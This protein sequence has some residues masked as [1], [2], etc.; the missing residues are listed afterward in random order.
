MAASPLVIL[1]G[2]AVSLR[3]A[4]AESEDPFTAC[5]AAT[6]SRHFYD[7][8]RRTGGENS[9]THSAAQTSCMGPST[10]HDLSP[11][12]DHTSLRMTGI[13]YESSTP[14]AT[15]LV[16]ATWISSQ[17]GDTVCQRSIAT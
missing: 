11:A 16:M 10:T 14:P 13:G 1:S 8:Q 15:S 12:K 6:M 5:S 17:T 3:E 9:L 2:V 7:E 4:A